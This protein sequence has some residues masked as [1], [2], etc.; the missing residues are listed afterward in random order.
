MFA[1]QAKATP[2]AVA[3]VQETEDGTAVLT[4]KQL[5]KLTDLLA[6][7]L[8]KHGVKPDSCVGIYMERCTDYVIS[9]IAILKAGGAYMPLDVSYPKTLLMDVF[10]DAQP[11]LILTNETWESNLKG[12]LK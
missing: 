3:V 1:R 5:D 8:Q 2:D 10:N 12:I 6:G 11:A 9:Y 4:Y 7:Y